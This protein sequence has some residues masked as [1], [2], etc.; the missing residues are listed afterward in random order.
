MYNL[1]DMDQPLCKYYINSSHNTYLSG[2]K[3]LFSII[4]LNRPYYKIKSESLKTWKRR[5]DVT[6]L[7]LELPFIKSEKKNY[8]YFAKN[9]LY[10]CS[11]SLKVLKIDNQNILW[12]N[13]F[14][15]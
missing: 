11:V 2:I 7:K 9:T 4:V 1:Q 8:K 15:F 14:F 13:I 5:T 6:S 10:I 3:S 12:V